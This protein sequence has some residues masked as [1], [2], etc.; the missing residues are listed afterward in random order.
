VLPL[1]KTAFVEVYEAHF[2]AAYKI[3]LTVYDVLDKSRLWAL[4]K[5]DMLA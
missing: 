1:T 2:R 4:L 3:R 5:I